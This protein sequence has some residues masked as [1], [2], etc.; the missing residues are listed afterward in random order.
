MTIKDK[1]LMYV[2][3]VE[4][5]DKLKAVILIKS[6]AL[7]EGIKRDVLSKVDF[8][9]EPSVVYETTKIAIRDI[10]GDSDSKESNKVYISK[11][12]HQ[13]QQRWRSRSPSWQRRNREGSRSRSGDRH[14]E[15]LEEKEDRHEEIAGTSPSS[16]G[17]RHQYQVVT[18]KTMYLFFL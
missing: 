13:P 14:H 18:E 2:R 10:L 1:E 9:K 12:W 11:P 5:N 7:D 17:I 4:L 15:V 3:K 8:N 16:A 6:L